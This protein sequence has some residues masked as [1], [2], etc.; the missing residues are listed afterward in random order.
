M[1]DRI[2]TKLV[3]QLAYMDAHPIQRRLFHAAAS[4]AS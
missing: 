2:G 1:K 3:L 4:D